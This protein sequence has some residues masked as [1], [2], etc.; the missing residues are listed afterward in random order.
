MLQDQTLVSGHSVMSNEPAGA[1]TFIC[2]ALADLVDTADISEFPVLARRW[3]H[4]NHA[5]DEQAQVDTGTSILWLYKRSDPCM[6]AGVGAGAGAGTHYC[7][8]RFFPVVHTRIFTG[9]YRSPR[10]RHSSLSAA[11]P[12]E[13]VC[14]R[15]AGSAVLAELTTEP[16]VRA[17]TS[18][19]LARDGIK[20]FGDLSRCALNPGRHSPSANPAVRGPT[21]L[22]KRSL[23]L[24]LADAGSSINTFPGCG[25]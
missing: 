23:A 15:L 25:S 2:T 13:D 7:L 20:A 19:Y 4:R 10:H 11:P 24:R 9:L 3:I 21:R 1:M 17:L 5:F 6:S 18:V 12:A 22:K 8:A 14:H 16:S